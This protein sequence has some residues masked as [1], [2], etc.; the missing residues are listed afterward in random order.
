MLGV[1]RLAE[2]GWLMFA[3]QEMSIDEQEMI[4]SLGAIYGVTDCEKS[5]LNDKVISSSVLV[6]ENALVFFA[7][8]E[9]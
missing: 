7:W 6:T 2:S 5:E 8:P 1:L 9:E 3:E 4:N